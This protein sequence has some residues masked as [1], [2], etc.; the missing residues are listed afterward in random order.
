[1][2]NQRIWKY[3]LQVKDTQTIMMPFGAR[4]LCVQNQGGVPCLWALCDIDAEKICR[5]I[6]TIGTGHPL[7]AHIRKYIGTFQ[8]EEGS[9]V[10]HVFERIHE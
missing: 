10:W 9:L 3:Q 6:D 1:M 5:T 8:Q 4:M 7:S 2:F